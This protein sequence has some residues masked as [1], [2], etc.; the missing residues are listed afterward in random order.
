[1]R[2]YLRLYVHFLRFSFSRAMEFRVDFFFRV[3]MDTVFY[4]V[5]LSFFAILYGHID[6]LADWNLDQIYI[7]VSGIFLMDALHMTVFANNAWY[8][9]FIVNQGD[10]DYYL[11]RPVSTLFF[12]SLREFAANSFL[13]VLI[14][15]GIF[16]WSLARYAGEIGPV[17]ITIYVLL[18]INGT[19]IYWMLQMLFLIPVFWMHSSIGLRQLFFGL[20]LF[21]ER[22]HKIYPGVTRT[23]LLTVVPFGLVASVPA[24]ILF[25]GLTLGWAI[26]ITCVVAGL[27]GVLRLAWSFGLRSY[28]SASS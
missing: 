17:D 9:P 5:S 26:H 28:S 2:R 16:C 22:P 1:M 13:N 6:E 19:V 23:I 24:T 20:H 18:I 27:F 12:V 7:F 21:S 8:F 14:A 3:V 11:V 10:L 15:I 4:L 25:E